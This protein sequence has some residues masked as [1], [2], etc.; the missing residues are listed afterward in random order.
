M[1]VHVDG[2]RGANHHGDDIDI[3]RGYHDNVNEG[4]EHHD[5]EEGD[6]EEEEVQYYAH[7]LIMVCSKTK[8]ILIL[9][10]YMSDKFSAFKSEDFD[11]FLGDTW[12]LRILRHLT[13]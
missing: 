3:R 7:H 1:E 8:S 6:E 11:T 4:Y 5:E 12:L 13:K 9:I 2:I 10:N